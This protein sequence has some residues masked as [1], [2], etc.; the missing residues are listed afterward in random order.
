VACCAAVATSCASSPAAPS[1]SESIDVLD[2][3]VGEPA[4]WPRMGDQYQHQIVEPSRVC[5]TK[6]TLGW[7]YECWRWDGDWIYHDV[8]HAI[9]ARRWEYYTFS[10]GRW[11]P[12]RLAVGTVW[13]LD[14]PANRIRWVDADCQPQ[15]EQASPYRVRAWFE[16]SIDAGGDLGR[17]DAVVLEYQPDPEHAAPGTAERF[18]FARGA[19]WFLWTRGDGARVAFNRIG[20]IARLPTPLCARDFPGTR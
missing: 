1:G 20:G 13:S 8:D 10:D 7:M 18:Y 11:L 9:D 6:Y 2:F 4:L 17:R 3:V 16:P 15:P 12:R 19:G 5:W 14:L